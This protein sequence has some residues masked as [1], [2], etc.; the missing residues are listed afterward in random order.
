MAQDRDG[1]WVVRQLDAL[2]HAIRQVEKN[3]HFDSNDRA[4]LMDAKRAVM[5]DYTVA[6]NTQK[7]MNHLRRQVEALNCTIGERNKEVASWRKELDFKTPSIVDTFGD[8]FVNRQ[9]KIIAERNALQKQYDTLAASLPKLRASPS[10]AEAAAAA[11]RSP[12]P[13]TETEPA[14]DAISPASPASPPAR[15]RRRRHSSHHHQHRRRSS[16]P[17]RHSPRQSPRQSQRHS[18]RQSP[19]QSSQR[20]STGEPASQPAQRQYPSSQ[21]PQP[22][23]QQPTQR[24]TQRQTQSRSP[25]RSPD[26]SRKR[27]PKRAR[28]LSDTDESESGSPQHWSAPA[29]ESARRPSTTPSAQSPPPRAPSVTSLDAGIRRDSPEPARRPLQ[30]QDLLSTIFVD[31]DS[32]PPSQVEVHDWP[33]A[34]AGSSV[35]LDLDLAPP[36]RTY[37]PTEGLGL[38]LAEG[39]A[40]GRSAT[41]ASLASS[42]HAHEQQQRPVVGTGAAASGAL[43]ASEDEDQQQ[44]LLGFLATLEARDDD[45]S[46][47][48][49]DDRPPALHD[50]TRGARGI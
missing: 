43:P 30:P 23:A 31:P 18:P 1:E 45:F 14:R 39:L 26:R 11:C 33:P 40:A 12:E 42:P 38:S 36:S 19:R 7:Q 37:L 49:D 47:P 6:Y 20:P 34:A 8:Y 10:S 4:A 48:S 35:D 2:H 25:D 15:R 16:S 50:V 24:Q 32:F 41:P 27:T 5:E 28:T 21:L 44:N 17:P 13:E 3:A 9:L 46:S 29:P 22:R